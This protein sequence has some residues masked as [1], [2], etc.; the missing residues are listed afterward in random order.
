M[1]HPRPHRSNHPRRSSTSWIL[2]GAVATATALALQLGEVI[3]TEIIGARTGTWL[4]PS[5]HTW[6]PLAAVTVALVVL[7]GPWALLI[8]LVLLP[9]AE[10]AS[11]GSDV[12]T[13]AVL[14]VTLLHVAAYGTAGTWLRSRRVD[15]RDSGMADLLRLVVAAGFAAPVI[16]GFGAALTAHVV[17]PMSFHE[18]CRFALAWTTRDMVAVL[19]AVSLPFAVIGAIRDRRPLRRTTVLAGPNADR[20]LLAAQLSLVALSI[21]AAFA[22]GGPGTHPVYL[23]SPALLWLSATRGHRFA[24]IGVSFF[25]LGLIFTTLYE[26]HTLDLAGLRLQISGIAL[27]TLAVGA[28]VDDRRRSLLVHRRMTTALALSEARYRTVL[29]TAAE[30]MVVVGA[31]GTIDLANAAVEGLFG[32]DR[33]DLEG[34][35]LLELLP[36]PEGITAEEHL[37]ALLAA[38]APATSSDGRSMLGRRADGTTFPVRLSVSR[39]EHAGEVSYTAIVHDESDRHR[40]E[41]MLEHQ[42]THDALTDLPNRVLFHDRLQNSLEHLRRRPGTI[43]VLLVDLD[44]F[45]AINDTLGHAAGDHVLQETARRLRS[46]VRRSDTVARLGG[47]EFAILCDP[48]EDHNAAAAT[49]ARVLDSLARPFDGIPVALSPT[50][51]IGVRV[52]RDPQDQPHDIVREAD[53]ALYRAKR[54][55]RHCFRTFT[56]PDHT[57]DDRPIDLRERLDSGALVVHYQ[58]V[59]EVATGTIVAVEALARV[60]GDDGRIVPPQAFIAQA[61]RSGLIDRLGTLVA[62]RACAD[63]AAARAEHPGL[64][65]SVNVSPRQLADAHLV[66]TVAAALADA[67]LEPGAL[68]IEITETSSLAAV[69]DAAEV[70]AALSSMGVEIALD[71][72]GTGASSLELIRTL[73]VDE[74]KIDRSFVRGVATDDVDRDIVETVIDLARRRGLRVVAE[75]VETIEQADALAGLGCG[76]LQGF[77]Y[78]KPV[79]FDELLDALRQGARSMPSTGSSSEP[80]PAAASTARVDAR[81]PNR[82]A[83]S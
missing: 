76:H 54:D 5:T 62:R 55:G 46:A 78:S 67:G 28:Q 48:I 20:V 3:P 25:A 8:P 56:R 29:E 53:A 81:R 42:A 47:D 33:I 69:P 63:I 26:A 31:D 17:R 39:S 75:G 14:V 52:V 7:A 32:R 58:P 21:A 82:S 73:H 15:L 77:L 38:T 59:L 30:G 57:T 83:Q 35:S 79:P 6:Y 9:V 37:E 18:Y 74:L 40:V 51:S 66:D 19:V 1:S 12:P 16:T 34:G 27:L 70:V 13:A 23:A 45:K 49:A 50:V 36:A 11:A 10:F 72:F 24:A 71:D 80:R 60:L 68:T 4:D 65:V 2:T 43:A 22:I 61:E 64:R 44:R 41:A